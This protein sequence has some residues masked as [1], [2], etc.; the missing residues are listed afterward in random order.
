MMARYRD[1]LGARKLVPQELARLS[2]GS[3]TRATAKADAG[4]KK[5]P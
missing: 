5:K 2:A 3:P 4:S 1:A